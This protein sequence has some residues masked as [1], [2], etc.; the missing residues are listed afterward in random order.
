MTYERVVWARRTKVT[1]KKLRKLLK[2]VEPGLEVKVHRQLQEEGGSN[3]QDIA[4][5]TKVKQV[6]KDGKPEKVYLVIG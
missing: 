3:V 2:K 4:F 6:D 5:L 1:A